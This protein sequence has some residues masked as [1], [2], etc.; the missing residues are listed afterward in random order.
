MGM[1]SS[2]EIRKLIFL[3]YK[4]I[5]EE[6]EKRNLKTK[7][8][9]KITHTDLRYAITVM[10]EKHSSCRWQSEKIKKK[11]YY[12]QYEG[13]IWLR[14]VYFSSYDMKFIDKDIKWF[15]NRI[16]WYQNQFN[17][18]NI[19][20]PD[21]NYGIIAMNKKELADYFKKSI[22]TIENG[23]REYEAVKTKNIRHYKE[24][25]LEINEAVIEWLLKNRFKNKYISLLENY[26]MQLTEIFKANG[27]YYD[28]YFG[29]N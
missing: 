15:E 19:E 11:Y 5:L 21:I 17:K 7:S 1:P 13:F 8:G 24:D 12:I 9:K 4:E 2:E 29:R 25:K 20:Y 16:L 3:D 23:I 28:N 22:R 18:N 6:L 26:K 27:G 14:D 10:N